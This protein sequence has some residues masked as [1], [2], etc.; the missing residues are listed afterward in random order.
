VEHT[1]QHGAIP[2]SVPEAREQLWAGT[3]SP[4]YAE[5]ST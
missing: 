5:G 2:A 4:F 3:F 1:K